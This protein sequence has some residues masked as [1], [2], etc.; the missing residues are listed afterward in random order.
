MIYI[1]TLANK[2]KLI[3]LSKQWKGV[4]VDHFAM[5]QTFKNYFGNFTPAIGGGGGDFPKPGVIFPF[6]SIES[7]KILSSSYGLHNQEFVISIVMYKA[8]DILLLSL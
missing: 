7:H 2:S 1:N 4:P 8:L 3:T 5:H 6:L